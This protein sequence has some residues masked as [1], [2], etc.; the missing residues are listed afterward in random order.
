MIRKEKNQQIVESN[1]IIMLI[2]NSTLIIIMWLL[3]YIVLFIY[4]H[5]NTIFRADMV[6]IQF[7]AHLNALKT[8]RKCILPQICP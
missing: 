2:R 3:K 6:P 8:I 1:K 4:A 5:Q 7:R